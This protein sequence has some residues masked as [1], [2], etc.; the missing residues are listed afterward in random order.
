MSDRKLHL[1]RLATQSPPVFF[2]MREAIGL[3]LGAI[4][5]YKMRAALTILGVVMGIMTVTGMSAI[6]AGLNRNVASIIDSIGSS[7]I[8]IDRS[9][10]FEY[11]SR[12]ERRR[13]K[14]LTE[15]EVKAILERCPAVR[16]VAPTE[17]VQASEVKYGGERLQEFNV[18]GTTVA[19]EVVTNAVIERGRFFTEADVARSAPLAVIG[20]EIVKGLFPAVEPVGKEID[21]DGRRVRVIGVLESKGRIAGRGE[22]NSIVVPLGA[23][24]KRPKDANYLRARAKPIAPELIE[25]ASEQIREVLRRKRRLRFWQNDDFAVFTQD[26]FRDLYDRLTKGIYLVMIAISSIGLVVGGVGVMNIMLVSVTERTREI[27]VRKALGATKRDIRWQFLTE[28]MTV[29]GLGGTIGIVVGA[30]VAWVVNLFSPFPAT[31]QPM[32]VALAF[33]SSVAVGL[34]F[35]LWPAVKAARLDP[36]EALRYE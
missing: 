13:R 12:Q 20:A 30:L 32:W 16:A 22:D 33:L 28:A 27:G 21:I 2:A 10:P 1:T 24:Q 36:I 9:A 4:R 25:D 26:T 3:G 18:I 17:Y 19:Y 23:F 35:G 8:L 15:N 11:V 29:T 7:V 34:T 6:I 14:N 5:A 31:L